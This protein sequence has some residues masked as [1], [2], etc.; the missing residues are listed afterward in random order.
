MV[1]E[2]LIA[3]GSNLGSSAG[4]PSATL[5][6][7]LAAL[8]AQGVGLRRVSRFFATPCFPA[9][10]GPDYVN[11]CALVRAPL[12]PDALLL[13]LHAVEQAFDR[14]RIQRWGSR[15]LDLDLLAMADRVLPDA[16]TQTVWRTLPPEDQTRAS[17]E[18]L[19]LPHPRIQDRAFVLGPLADIAAGWTH[20]LLCRNV[21]QLLA[22]LPPGDRAALQPLPAMPL[23]KP[24]QPR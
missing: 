2:F 4:G 24:E 11:A 17:P 12:S 23:V 8:T 6:A 1:Q 10:A 7:A 14:E 18:T 5:A 20:P 16:E 3:L 21:A 19:I 9:G 15:T 22:D 13:K